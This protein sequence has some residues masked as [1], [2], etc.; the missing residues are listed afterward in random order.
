MISLEN[1]IDDIDNIP[2]FETL[3]TESLTDNFDEIQ[4]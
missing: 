1:L 4:N 2:Q 3:S